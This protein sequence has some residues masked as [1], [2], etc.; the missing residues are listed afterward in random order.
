MRSNRLS[1]FVKSLLIRLACLCC[2]RVQQGYIPL[3]TGRQEAPE[4]A[5]N[6]SERS[7]WF[8]S[9]PAH[10]DARDLLFSDYPATAD[11][12]EGPSGYA[13]R[14]QARRYCRNGRRPDRQG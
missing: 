12:A 11:A 7:L 3:R 13:R 5:L 2:N 9:F 1:A 14:G 4:P 6:E 10:L 8:L